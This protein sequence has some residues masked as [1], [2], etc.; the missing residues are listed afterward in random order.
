MNALRRPLLCFVAGL[1]SASVV[2]CVSVL[3]KD[4]P[5]QLY[6]F[7]AARTVPAAK[8][9]GGERFQV[10]V[11]NTDFEP[12]AAGDRILTVDGDQTAY[13][14]G[15]RWVSPALS[16]FDAAVVRAFT[17]DDGPGRLLARGEPAHPDYTLKLDVRTFE[18]RYISGAS[19]APTVRVEVYAALGATS[20]KVDRERT[21]TGEVQASDNR[22]GAIA[23]AFDEALAKVFSQLVPWVDAKGQT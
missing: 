22:I 20:E 17:A 14:K 21:F 8:S 10:N 2:A 1:G 11:A 19:G 3:P 5:V 18:V 15:A 9:A 16:L 13:I 6:R 12:A 4:E 7:E 23:T